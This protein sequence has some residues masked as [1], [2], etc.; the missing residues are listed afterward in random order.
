MFRPRWLTAGL[1]LLVGGGLAL[2]IPGLAAVGQSSPPGSLD[3][4]VSPAQIVN[5]G[6]AALVS[7]E[8]VCQPTDYSASVSV[9]LSQKSGNGIAAGTTPFEEVPCTGLPEAFTVPITPTTKPFMRGTA[10]GQLWFQDCGNSGCLTFMD[11][12]SIT[13]TTK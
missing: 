4:L 11:A 7:F 9:S 12:R 13:L 6:A 10:F 1:A 3:I 8:V 2:A 5:K